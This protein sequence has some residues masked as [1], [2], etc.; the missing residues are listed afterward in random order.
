MGTAPPSFAFVGA[1]G[2]GGYFGGC[3][4]RAGYDVAFLARGAH[5]DAIRHNGLHVEAPD[6]GFRVDVRASD[7]PTALPPVD[8]VFLSVKLWD[9]EAAARACR[10]LLGADTAVLSMQ[11]GIL[12]ES[13]LSEVL[14][15]EHVMGGLAEV[16]AS[17]TAP[18]QVTKLGPAQRIRF[19]ELDGSRSARAERLAEHLAAPGMEGSLEADITSAL[20]AKFIFITGLSALTALTR[21]PI[22][23]VRSTPETRELLQAVVAEAYAVGVASGV[24]LHEKLVPAAIQKMDA[25]PGEIRASMAIDL[26]AGRRLELP[27]LSGA[28]VRLGATHGVPTPANAFVVAALKLHSEGA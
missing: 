7:E 28:V 16:S 20:W 11:N 3:L 21:R 9:T 4:A 27:W 15:N 2:V 22:G 25:L 18:G 14:G 10:P 12:A 6:G 23:D 1:G 19:G 26:A 17:I 5:L 13:L 8:Y 24:A